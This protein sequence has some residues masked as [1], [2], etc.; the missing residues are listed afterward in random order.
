[1]RV[2]VDFSGQK[3][4]MLTIDNFAN[5]RS[6]SGSIWNATC[7][8]GNKREVDSRNIRRAKQKGYNISCGKCEGATRISQAHPDTA[9]FVHLY[10]MYKGN[11]K[12]RRMEFNLDWDQFGVLTKGFCKY[13]GVAPRQKSYN[14][15]RESYY[16]YNG[17][18]RVDSS[19]GYIIDNCVSCCGV[20]NVMKRDMSV[21]VFMNHIK[22]I[23]SYSFDAKTEYSKI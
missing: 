19:R 13:C 23:L 20:C 9:A 2:Y 10:N 1:M 5:K 16:E 3:V 6:K 18:D 11:A 12:T 7:D 4:G 22:R 15:N 21:D 8:C 14:S 17:I